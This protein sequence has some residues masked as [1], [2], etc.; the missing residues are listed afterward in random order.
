MMQPQ[1]QRKKIMSIQT[2]A[3]AIET[4]SYAYRMGILKN[5]IELDKK[6]HTDIKE[7]VK[8]EDQVEKCAKKWRNDGDSWFQAW[9]DAN[10]KLTR[11]HIDLEK[12]LGYTAQKSKCTFVSEFRDVMP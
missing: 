12:K 5:Y 4:Y 8:H 1:K 9:Y 6:Y 7:I 11:L 10:E 3:Y 2:Y